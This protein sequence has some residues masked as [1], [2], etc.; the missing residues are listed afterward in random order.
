MKYPG[1]GTYEFGQKVHSVLGTLGHAFAGAV[2]GSMGMSLDRTGARGTAGA[3]GYFTA[4]T[5]RR[6]VSFL[7][8]SAISG[9]A[10]I[11]G[12]AFRG[13]SGAGGA[14]ANMRRDSLK[15]RDVLFD[16]ADN[17]SKGPHMMGPYQTADEYKWRAAIGGAQDKYGVQKDGY[18]RFGARTPGEHLR[19]GGSNLVKHTLLSPAAWGLNIGMAAWMS[20]DNI[21]DPYNGMAKHLATNVGA[22]AGFIGGAA[23][24]SA[25][26]GALV[27]GL[28]LMH[29]LAAGIGFLGGGI[30]GAEA[31][32]AAGEAPWSLSAFGNRYGRKAAS[33]KSTFL[34]SEGAQT[35]RQRAMQSIRRSHMSARSAFG[36]E[37]LSYHA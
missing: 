18:R 34:D 35:M 14:Y 16:I 20:D 13:A 33:T 32:A 28:G 5:A 1:Q 24:G 25:I 11:G 19:K 9:I 31:G 30:L 8:Q 23:I 4:D 3:M 37:A 22:E 21:F 17:K 26:A 27:P 29:A 10:G 36:Q 12:A 2:G 7:G 15:R 6:G